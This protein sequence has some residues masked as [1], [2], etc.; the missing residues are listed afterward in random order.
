MSRAGPEQASSVE[1]VVFGGAKKCPVSKMYRKKSPRTPG[2]GR[3]RVWEGRASRWQAG[4]W[5]DWEMTLV[6]DRGWD[7]EEARALYGG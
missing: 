6:S 7:H 1:Q 3:G 5:S 4:T 2:P